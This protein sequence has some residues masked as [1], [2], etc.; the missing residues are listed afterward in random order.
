MWEDH[1]VHVKTTIFY[2]NLECPKV[3]CPRAIL[4]QM[5]AQTA[6]QGSQVRDAAPGNL[7]RVPESLRDM[8]GGVG[9]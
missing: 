3:M 5:P 7:C 6:G 4:E 9:V 1:R 2:K 8:V